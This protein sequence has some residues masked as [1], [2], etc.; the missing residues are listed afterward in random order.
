MKVS[1]WVDWGNQEIYSNFDD[2]KA[3]WKD[4]C[5][6]DE[7][8]V[9]PTKFDDWLDEHYTCGDVW[10]MNEKERRDV[11]NQYDSYCD[12]C[13]QDWLETYFD[14]VEINI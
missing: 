11:L 14:E 12:D 6:A 10:S 8:G 5:D 4:V 3:Q 7:V 9:A 1:I 13:F 2:I